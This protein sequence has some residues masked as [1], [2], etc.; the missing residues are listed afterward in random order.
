MDDNTQRFIECV[1]E[2]IGDTFDNFDFSKSIFNGKTKP[3]TYH[4]RIHDIKYTKAARQLLK[5]H[6]CR[7]CGTKS[8]KQTLIDRH[9]PLFFERAPIIHNGYYTYKNVVYQ[10]ETTKV[11]IT[12][13]KHG[14]FPQ[15]PIKHLAGQGCNRCGDERTSDQQR[16]GI[17]E[18][19]RKAIEKH[20][21]EHYN[22]DNVIYVNCD[23]NVVIYCNIHNKLFSQTPASHL[24][25]S[26][27]TDCGIEKRATEKKQ[28]ASENFRKSKNDEL[29]D[30]SKFIYTKSIEKS[31]LIC[32]K[33]DTEF[34][35]SPNNYLRGKGCPN[36]KKKTELKLYQALYPKYLSI[37]RELKVDWCRN[38]ETNKYYR[39]DFCIEELKII[40]ELDGIQHI[41]SAKFFDRK[42]SFEERHNRDVYKQQ[43][44]N[45]NGYHMIRILQEDVL[46]DKNDWLDNLIREVEFIHSNSGQ[47]HNRY[48]CDNNEY[49]IFRD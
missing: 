13:P 43:C 18:F 47:I 45:D 35:I 39:F 6:C 17:D 42:L 4:C 49:D 24:N 5:G 48:I 29:F 34:P 44:A 33:C 25:G 30:F 32:R 8:R 16:M 20:G 15:K 10:G 23:T 38:S 19:I 41:R 31:I 40:I 46:Y 14:D 28:I 26:G 22:Y 9:K 27:C 12:C 7:K 36:C 1:K 2:C 3:I 37:I 21:N 11:L